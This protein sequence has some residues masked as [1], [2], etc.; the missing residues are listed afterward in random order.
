MDVSIKDFN[1]TMA[2]GNKGI[3]L[4]VYDNQGKHLGD[5]LIGKA[6]L[7]WCKGR[8]RVGNG[9]QKNWEEVIQ[10]FES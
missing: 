4:Q 8:T 10:F 9:V 7:E 6:K 2:L 3:E 5:L 1:V